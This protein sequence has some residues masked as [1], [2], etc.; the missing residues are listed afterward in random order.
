MIWHLRERSAFARLASHGQRA[1]A[2]VLWCS[3]ILDPD[4]STPPRVA[5]AVGRAHGPAVVRNQVRRRLR[6][7]LR[8]A[9]TSGRLPSGDFL[10]GLRAPGAVAPFAVLQDDLDELLTRIRR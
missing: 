3:Y 4:V 5:F 9:E 1:R 6:A 10:F 2:G 7:L 8:T